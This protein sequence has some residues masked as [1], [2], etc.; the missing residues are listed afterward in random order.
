MGGQKGIALFYKYFAQLV[1]FACITVQKNEANEAYT[2]LNQISNSKTRYLNFFLFFKI[3]KIAKENDCTHLLFEHPYYAWMIILFKLFSSE[4]VIVHSH[5]IESE[6]FKSIGNGGGKYYGTT[7]ELRI[8]LQIMFGL[9]LMR[10]ENLLSF[11]LI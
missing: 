5:N 4:S 7:N 8:G 6:R 3:K 9:K 1:S 10:I 2:V 11:I